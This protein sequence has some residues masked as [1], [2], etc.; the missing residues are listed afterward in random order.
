ME[1]KSA[2]T[3]KQEKLK[4]FQKDAEIF[5]KQVLS[6]RVLTLHAQQTVPVGQLVLASELY[7]NLKAADARCMAFLRRQV[8]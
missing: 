8:R 1:Q 4:V 5:C 3:L 2:A 6:G 7:K